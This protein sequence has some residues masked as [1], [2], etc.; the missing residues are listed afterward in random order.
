MHKPIVI[1]VRNIQEAQISVDSWKNWATK[2]NY[3]VYEVN[4]YEDVYNVDISLAESNIEYDSILFTSD[5]TYVLPKCGDFINGC[6]TITYARWFGSFGNILKLK[7]LLKSDTISIDNWISMDL[8]FFPKKEFINITE[9]IRKSKILDIVKSNTQHLYQL[10][11][12]IDIPINYIK[13]D[14]SN[15]FQLSYLYNMCNMHVNELLNESKFLKLNPNIVNF[16]NL[17]KNTILTL[18]NL[19]KDST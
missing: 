14:Y 5:T 7:N 17:N 12:L 8:A 19:V 1:I 11:N 3:S 9:Q 16:N 15:D 6:E 4:G 13:R 10:T 18:M 2:H